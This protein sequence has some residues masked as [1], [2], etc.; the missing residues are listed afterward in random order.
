[1]SDFHR[2]CSLF[3]QIRQ[4]KY[5][6]QNTRVLQAKEYIDHHFNEPACLKDIYDSC[7][8]SRRRFDQLFKSEY[9][10]TPNAYIIS[11][12]LKFAKKLLI[13]QEISINEISELCGFSDVCYF[14]KVFKKETEMTPGEF[15]NKPL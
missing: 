11:Q 5:A 7:G 9:L 2:I 1:M 12:K 6:P 15:R 4:K 10:V 13:L 8:L 14:C 3:D